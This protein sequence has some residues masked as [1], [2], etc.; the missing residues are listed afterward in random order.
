MNIREIKSFML[1]MD[2][3]FYLGDR[4]LEGSLDF[5]RTLKRQG[6]EYI[7]LTNNSSKN[8]TVYAEKLKAMGIDEPP[9]R[10]FTSG[11]ATVMY[12]LRHFSQRRVF[13]FGTDCLEEEFT[14]AGFTLDD[15]SPE[16]VILGF[17]PGFVYDKLWALCRLVRSGLPYIATHPDVNCPVD[18]GDRM[19]DT[20]STIEF[21]KTSTGRAPDA[22]IGKPNRLI[23]DSVIEKYGFERESLAMVG[24][25]LMT[26]I[27]IGKNAG[28]QSVLVL[29]GETSMEDLRH[30]EHTPDFIFQSLGEMAE[31]LNK[32]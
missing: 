10:I 21:V 3:T 4:L 28:I 19:P 26:D 8:K 32:R 20:G 23:V 12:V 6:K 22:V 11:E 16:L 5:I 9:D 2:G 17:D 27:A 14:S 25:R 18:G 30:S 29:T 7:F 15:I 31:E 1:D 13:V 24:D